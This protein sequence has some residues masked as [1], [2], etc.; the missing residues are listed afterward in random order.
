MIE[1]IENLEFASILSY[2]YLQNNL[3][4]SI[5]DLNLASLTKLYLDENAISFVSGL[6]ACVKLEELH[7]A[8][9]RLPP[10]TSIEFD[11]S[12]L[13]AISGSL[14]VLEISGNSITTLIPFSRLY[15]LRKIFAENNL[16][17]D[18]S[19]IES[20][21]S[22]HHLEE[23]N[24]MHNPCCANKRYRDYAIGASADGFLMLDGAP[25]LKHQQVIFSLLK[26]L[27]FILY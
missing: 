12:S 20:I 21:I 7:V 1:V 19:D 14:K 5:P 13:I 9:Q 10:D 8:K 17:S 18:L 25:I 22:L 15:S 4:N 16:I 23:A 11:E 3:I 6:E 26:L 2:L 27:V 24:F